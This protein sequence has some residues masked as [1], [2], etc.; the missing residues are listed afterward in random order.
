[1]RAAD[2]SAEISDFASG[3][4]GC[5]IGASSGFFSTFQLL[6]YSL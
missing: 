3:I 5:T 1:L 4:F 2:F 6:R